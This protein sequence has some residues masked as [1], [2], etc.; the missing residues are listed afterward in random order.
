MA[1]VRFF[2]R[3][4]GKS[5]SLDRQLLHSIFI[6]SCRNGA[7]GRCHNSYDEQVDFGQQCSKQQ[8]CDCHTR[9]SP[10]YPVLRSIHFDSTIQ[11]SQDKSV[12][13]CVLRKISQV[14]MFTFL[15]THGDVDLFVLEQKPPGKVATDGAR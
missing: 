9:N 15:G 7:H 6:M 11:V 13:S 2:Y 10:A 1:L 5:F 12:F 14:Q 3:L 8:Q 4:D